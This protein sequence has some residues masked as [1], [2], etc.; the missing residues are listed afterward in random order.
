[1]DTLTHLRQLE[2]F[3]T[4]KPWRG[5]QTT[6]IIESAPA[7]EVCRIVISQEDV[8]FI[9]AARNAL[10]FLLD[11]AEAA[12]LVE[13]YE[14]AGGTEWWDAHSR[15]YEALVRLEGALDAPPCGAKEGASR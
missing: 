10:P 15:L 5:N 6:H 7:T 3:A 4:P 12:R 13:A 9:A 11:V 14:Q 2:T 1:M 8:E